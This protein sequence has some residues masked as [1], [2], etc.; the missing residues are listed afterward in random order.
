MPKRDALI[1]RNLQFRPQAYRRLQ[2]Q[3]DQLGISVARLVR[4][5][6]ADWLEKTAAGRRDWD[7]GV[8]PLEELVRR[9]K[10]RRRA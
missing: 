5:L 2:I 4:S 10:S 7:R 6:V 9:L 3:A 8:P 1:R